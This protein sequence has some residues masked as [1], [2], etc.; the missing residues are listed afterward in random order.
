MWMLLSIAFRNLVQARRRTGLLSLAIGLVTLLLVML[1]ALTDGINDNL[2]RSATVV[3]AGHVNVAGFYKATTTEGAPIVTNYAEIRKIVEENTPG[4]DFV[5]DRARGWS[6]LV[7]ETASVQA[8]LSG[9]DATQETRLLRELR[10]AKE[11]DYKEGGRDEVIGDVNRISEPETAILFAAQAERL[12][13]GVGDKFTVRT[14]T[15]SGR[16]STVDLTVIAVAQDLGMLSSWSIFVPKETLLALYQLDS[17]TTGAIW[18]YL[19]DIDEA[20]AVMNHLREVFVQKGYTLMEYQPQPFF[21][22]FEVVTGEDWVG[23]K[24]DLTTWKDE[25]SFLTWVLTA[26]NFLTVM[27]VSILV[28]IIAIGIMNVM[29]ASVRERTRE[30]GTMRAIGMTRSRV[31]VMFMLEAL[32]LGFFASSAGAALGAGVALAVDAANF[33]IPYSAVRA[34]L[35]AETL[36]LVIHPEPLLFSVG[37][38]TTFT[39]G[40]ALWPAIHA[41]LLRPVAAISTTE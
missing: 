26:F 41:A 40:S 37:L 33:V 3:S 35:L 18:V 39:A 14:E 22:K 8:A 36:N 5:T 2:I 28:V 21:F 7:S 34:I 13:I 9:I 6:K 30:I 12:G 17:D 4:L 29:W 38:L 1:L 11:S 16:T 31:L 32:M 10:L 15:S 25:V 20:P 19:K 27:L 24:L 23:Q